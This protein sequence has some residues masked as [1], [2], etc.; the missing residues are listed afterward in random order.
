MGVL[1][2]SYGEL[3]SPDLVK[4]GTRGGSKTE[5]LGEFGP[6][7]SP[8]IVDVRDQRGIYVLSHE[9]RVVYVGKADKVSLVSRLNL[10]RSDHL[11]GRWDRFSWF[12][13]RGA[14]KTG[15]LGSEISTKN[16]TTTD[17]IKTFESLLIAV[18][19]P[20][21]NKRSEE[22]PGAQLVLQAGAE[23]PRPAASYLDELRGGVADVA[24]QLEQIEKRLDRMSADSDA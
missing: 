22:L 2:R 21:R 19:E 16:T 11:A 14:L 23:R 3:W 4:W 6:R 8:I 7:R 5:L 17:L 24:T 15:K 13:I 18:T 1:I 12:G 20:P 10:H 9:W